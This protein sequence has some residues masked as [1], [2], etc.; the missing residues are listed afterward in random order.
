MCSSGS[1]VT[2]ENLTLTNGKAPDGP[3]G[4]QELQVVQAA[5]AA[6]FSTAA[7]SH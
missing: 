6:A 5:V 1:V 4:G 2:L 3:D 7:P